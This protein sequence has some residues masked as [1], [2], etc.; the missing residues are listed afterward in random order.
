MHRFNIKRKIA[1]KREHRIKCDCKDKTCALF[2]FLHDRP[3]TSRNVFFQS[4]C[5]ASQSL[6]EYRETRK[7]QININEASHGVKLDWTTHLVLKMTKNR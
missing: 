5:R 4:V 3:Q 2:P 7:P 6:R 1:A